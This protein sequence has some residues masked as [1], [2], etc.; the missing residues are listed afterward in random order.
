MTIGIVLVQLNIKL[1]EFLS[2]MMEY[3]YVD[4]VQ[5]FLHLSRSLLNM[6]PI[7]PQVGKV[8]PKH[9]VGPEMYVVLLG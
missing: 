1:T 4:A 2:E 7:T 6:D 9:S 5:V 8:R 3:G